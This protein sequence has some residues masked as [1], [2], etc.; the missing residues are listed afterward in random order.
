LLLL[1][2]LTLSLLP[3]PVLSQLEVRLGCFLFLQL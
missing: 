1:V 2:L 3:L